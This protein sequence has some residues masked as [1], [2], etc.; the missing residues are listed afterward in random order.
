MKLRVGQRLRLTPAGPIF[1]AVRVNS[2]ATYLRSVATRLV[3]LEGREFEA[4]ESRVLAV[5]PNAAV[6]PE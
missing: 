4:Q 6:Y 1:Q 5:S 2:C 3:Q